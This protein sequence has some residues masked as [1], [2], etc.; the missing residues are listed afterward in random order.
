M[1]DAQRGVGEIRPFAAFGA[2]QKHDAVAPLPQRLAPRQ[3]GDAEPRDAF[4]QSARRRLVCDRRHRLLGER[5][6]AEFAQPAHAQA[7]AR[8]IEGDLLARVD[9]RGKA[10]L[11]L[12]ERDR[13]GQ[14]NAARGG[15][16]GKFGDGEIRLTRERGGGIDLRA[17]AVRQQKCAGSL[18]RD[19]SRCAPGRRGRGAPRRSLPLLVGQGWRAISAHRSAAVCASRAR[20]ERSRRS[21]SRRT[22][23]SRS[24]PPRPRS[25]IRTAISAACARCLRR[26]HRPPCARA[27]APAA[28]DELSPFIGDAAVRIDGAELGRA[29]TS[30]R[31][32]PGAAA[33]R[34]TASFSA[35][36]PQAARSRAKPERSAERISGREKA[37]SAAV[38]GSSQ[39]R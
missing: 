22:R 10:R 12:G 25:P 27:A 4:G 32:A 21:A 11:D 8:R 7:R 14:E 28:G 9:A 1:S 38:C 6:R 5:E 20:G 13:R 24:S 19:F 30:P 31:R 16:A 37:S 15:A 2:A 36:A 17:A 3:P 35:L 33:D 29:K 18:R 26:R 23:R 34:G 39:R